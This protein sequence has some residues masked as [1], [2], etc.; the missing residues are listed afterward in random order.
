MSFVP[1][2]D[3]T[4]PYIFQG[5]E[6]SLGTAIVKYL[7]EKVKEVVDECEGL[8]DFGSFDED[9]EEP[10][11]Q[12]WLVQELVEDEKH[13]EIIKSV[14]SKKF[15]DEI[16]ELLENCISEGGGFRPTLL[17]DSDN[18][19][20]YSEAENIESEFNEMEFKVALFAVSHAAPKGYD[21]ESVC[22][23]WEQNGWDDE[24]EALK[25]LG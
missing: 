10:C 12:A 20:L 13:V 8:R 22:Y 24:V 7:F 17:A 25:S 3:L 14:V 5:K 19:D 18:S 15:V 6:H 4:K 23:A 16:Q 1:V 2:I 9:P 11:M 21:L